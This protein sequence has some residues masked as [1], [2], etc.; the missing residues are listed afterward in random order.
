MMTVRAA[1]S[2]PMSMTVPASSLPELAG[3][4]RANAPTQAMGLIGG[5]PACLSAS[6]ARSATVSAAP[7]SPGAIA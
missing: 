1:G 4:P 5:R 3:L 6:T 7:D 2:P